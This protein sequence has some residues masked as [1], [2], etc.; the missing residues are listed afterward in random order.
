MHALV[1]AL[2]GG[3]VGQKKG[4]SAFGMCQRGVDSGDAPTNLREDEE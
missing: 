2:I 3:L 4:R 1:G